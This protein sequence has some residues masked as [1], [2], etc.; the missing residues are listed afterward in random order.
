MAGVVAVGVVAVADI[1]RSFRGGKDHV[2]KLGEGFRFSDGGKAVARL[3]M[4]LR[5]VANGTSREFS[6]VPLSQAQ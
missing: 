6:G 4:E 1:E 3:R 5:V 2:N